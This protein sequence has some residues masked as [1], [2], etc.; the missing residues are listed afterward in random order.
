MP[1]TV[2]VK[3]G[4]CVS[5]IAFDHGLFWETVWNDPANA[6]LRELR[7][8]PNILAEGDEVVVPDKRVASVSCATG[9]RHVFRRK[10]VPET[11]SLRL[12]D[13]AG[14]PR[15]NVPYHFSVGSTVRQGTSDG[16]GWIHEYVTPQPA[17]AKLII[18][19]TEIYSVAIG[20]LAPLASAEGLQQRLRNLGYTI[21]DEPGTIAGSTWTAIERFLADRGHALPAA[22][23]ESALA[24][25]RAKLEQVHST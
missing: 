10:G 23:D 15:A 22:R 17:V 7:G 21:H 16:D 11:V 8:N 3:A 2:K 12:L 19:A 13:A 6:A 24:D 14:A 20:H 1:V 9:K 18:S 4:E 5:T 25:V